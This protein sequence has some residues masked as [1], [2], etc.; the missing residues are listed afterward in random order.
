MADRYL[1]E[2]GAPDGYLLEDSSG[3]V[4]LET[5]ASSNYLW[6]IFPL[7]ATLAITA[8]ATP[9]Y[10][11]PDQ[12]R[13]PFYPAVTSSGVI[14]GQM[15]AMQVHVRAE[16]IRQPVQQSWPF[17]RVTVAVQS[18]Q[19]FH[20]LLN[21][22]KSV[23]IE[24]EQIRQSASQ[25]WPWNRFAQ[26][27][28]PLNIFRAADSLRLEVPDFAQPP[29]ASWP[30]GRVT[31]TAQPPQSFAFQFNAPPLPRLEPESYSQPVTASWP[32]NRFAQPF[33][34]LTVW[35]WSPSLRLDAPT[36]EQP[37][38]QRWNYVN[39]TQPPQPF[40]IWA[41][42]QRV[43]IEPESYSVPPPAAWTFGRTFTVI[44]WNWWQI[45]P[46][47]PVPDTTADQRYD[48]RSRD[49][50]ADWRLFWVT[51]TDPVIPPVVV[52]QPSGGWWPDYEHARRMRDVRRRK[53]E[54][55]ER[56]QRE[57]QDATDREIARLLREQEARDADREDLRR[58]QRLADT[59]A[60]KVPDLP[61]NV[62]HAILNAQDARTRNSLEQ[63]RRVI[64]QAIEAEDM[65][66]L[67]FLLNETD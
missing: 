46:P 34:P 48:Y 38:P 16:P 45:Q 3:V 22:Q 53:L 7:I 29:Q 31:V 33:Q 66:V 49:F 51:P 59:Y 54:Q 19:S 42:P 17:G 27:F 8:C 26:P 14:P 11:Q 23:A 2:S 60:A 13:W 61:Q 1:L 20:F 65:A 10:R 39:A 9:E 30:Y 21:Q 56:D 64:E 4:L 57:I 37:A 52:D 58:L 32:W 5:P 43:T 40:S 41:T 36:F 24:A 62:R 15:P 25:A 67:L 28:Q 50:G 47:A 12:Q 35:P 6:Q 18:P 44:G 63:M 55:E